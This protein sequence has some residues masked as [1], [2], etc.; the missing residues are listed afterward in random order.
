MADLTKVEKEVELQKLLT[1]LITAQTKG[2]ND[3]I[4]ARNDLDDFAAMNSGEFRDRASQ[5]VDDSTREGFQSFVKHAAA[6][7]ASMKGLKEVFEDAQ[8][9]AEEG[10]KN[11]LLNRINVF[12][13]QAETVLTAFDEVVDSVRNAG[14]IDGNT[15]LEVKNNIATV[16]EKIKALKTTLENPGG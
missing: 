1:A 7:A 10:E 15:A 8:K 14:K 5:A 13:A 9:I 2:A 3:V 11:L 6:V 16:L 4:A 12:A